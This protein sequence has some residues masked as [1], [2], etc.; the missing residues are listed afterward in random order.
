[1][2]HTTLLQ[3][4]NNVSG[5]SFIGLDTLTEV[6]LKGGA[7]NPMQGRVT[8]AMHGASVMVFQNKNINGYESMIQRRLA[9]EGKDPGSFKL[10]ERAWG[11]R[12]PNLPIVEHLKD[13]ETQYYL[14][15]IFLNPG[16]TEYMLDGAPIQ[17]GDIV[18]LQQ[19]DQPYQ[20]GLDNVVVI[21]TFKA[22]SIVEMRVDGK[23][24]N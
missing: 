24:F 18:G 16:K 5:A 12:V 14:E 3:A 4:V 19:H 8:K 20:G 23:I 15:V 2:K 6:K 13:G 21:R 11:T 1:M 17:C 7:K 22:D 9:I 10:G